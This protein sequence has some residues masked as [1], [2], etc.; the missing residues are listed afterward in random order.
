MLPPLSAVD[1]V[2]FLL[3]SLPPNPNLIF[4]H[5]GEAKLKKVICP[6]TWKEGSRNTTEPGG[7]GRKVGENKLLSSK[8][9]YNP[10]AKKCKVCKMNLHQE[11]LYCQGCAYKK[12]ICAMCGKKILENVGQYKQSSK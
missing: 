11:G 1:I 6:D 7:G 5:A 9:R 8:A 2:S 12:G 3:F 10:Y 4:W